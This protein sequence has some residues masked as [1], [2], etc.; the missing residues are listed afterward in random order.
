MTYPI[1]YIVTTVF[2]F[3]VIVYLLINQHLSDKRHKK[4]EDELMDRL[5]S[6]NFTEYAYGSHIL[7]EVKPKSINDDLEPDSDV[8]PVD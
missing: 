5:M 4:R 7:S 1:E 2:L 3:I 6:R 8:V